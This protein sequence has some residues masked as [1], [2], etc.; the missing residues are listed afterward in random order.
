M[1]RA[2]EILLDLVADLRPRPWSPFGQRK[3]LAYRPLT[4]HV[5]FLTWCG[6][7]VR[8]W[9]VDAANAG[10]SRPVSLKNAEDR[11]EIGRFLCLLTSAE[12]RGVL[13]GRWDPTRDLPV[14]AV[15]DSKTIPVDWDPKHPPK[16]LHNRSWPFGSRTAVWQ[17]KTPEM[18]T[19]KDQSRR[20]FLKCSWVPQHRLGHEVKMQQ[21][22]EGVKGSPR[23][24]GSAVIPSHV[25]EEGFKVKTLQQLDPTARDGQTGLYLCAIVY[26]HRIGRIIDSKIP[27]STLAYLH[28]QLVDTFLS[29]AQKDLHYRDLNAGNMLIQDGSEDKLLLID[30]GGMRESLRPRGEEWRGNL[31]AILKRAQDDAR[32]AN[33]MFL[34]SAYHTSVS[35]GKRWAINM[36]KVEIDQGRLQSGTPEDLQAEMERLA[37]SKLPRLRELLLSLIQLSHRYIDD[38]EGA[39]YLHMWQFAQ[40]SENP[41]T[42]PQVEQFLKGTASKQEVWSSQENWK[43]VSIFACVAPA[44]EFRSAETEPPDTSAVTESHH[45]RN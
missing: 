23:P 22:L 16:L 35:V 25:I 7:I 27:T 5:Y 39:L 43:E 26:E 13:A 15:L 45:L 9:Y 1:E 24:L 14:Q 42:R 20:L 8:L 31:T 6:K 44:W 21:C 12:C 19:D 33:P 18:V 3:L 28:A 32:S 37:I 29:Y 36:A 17:G 41:E 34:P 2:V 11:L 40:K 10:H 4:S 38:L 30:Q